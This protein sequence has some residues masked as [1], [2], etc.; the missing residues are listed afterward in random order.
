MCSQPPQPM[1]ISCVLA[2]TV[3]QFTVAVLANGDYTA[4]VLL[5][6]A[7]RTALVAHSRR[8]VRVAQR[9]RLQA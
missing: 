8:W 1:Q 3:T 9:Q 7:H 4:L 2:G 5:S 6:A